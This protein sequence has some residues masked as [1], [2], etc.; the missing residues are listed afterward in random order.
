MEIVR[1]GVLYFALVFGAGFV[2]GAIRTLYVVPRLSTRMAKL[3]EAPIMLIVT[4]V[5]VRWV[6][7]RFAVP[8]SLSSS[9]RLEMGFIA[10]GLLLVAEFT[11]VRR[12]RGI[13]LREYLATRDRI[14]GTAY[15]VLL[16]IFAVMPLL[17]ARR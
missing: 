7:L 6:V 14:S 9:S 17:V 1:A 10:L 3:L 16:V 2:F 8:S 11:L 5:V 12:L 4:L 13:S 15:Y